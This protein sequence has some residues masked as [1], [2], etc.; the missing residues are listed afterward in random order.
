MNAGA[1]M[2]V[3]SFVEELED[4]FVNTDKLIIRN[5][6]QSI[7]SGKENINSCSQ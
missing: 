3:N 5:T 6:D 4:F 1:Q 2:A 7:P